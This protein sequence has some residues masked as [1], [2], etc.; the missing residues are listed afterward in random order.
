M[1]GCRQVK[2]LWPHT[3]GSYHISLADLQLTTNVL[4]HVPHKRRLWTVT[5]MPCARYSRNFD[6]I[7]FDK[8]DT[9]SALYTGLWPGPK[10]N[11][12]SSI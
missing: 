8:S 3:V 12:S 9:L 2:G 11:Y 5:V 10:S 6:I 1:H 4:G 7:V